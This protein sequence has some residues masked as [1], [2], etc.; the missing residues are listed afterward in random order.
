M[1]YL[2]QLTINYVILSITYN[3]DMTIPVATATLILSNTIIFCGNHKRNRTEKVHYFQTIDINYKSWN[4]NCELDWN[5]VFV[6]EY[7]SVN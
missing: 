3:D 1:T 2:K 6:N 5:I 7:A 4:E